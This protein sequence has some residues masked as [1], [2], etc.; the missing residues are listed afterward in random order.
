M[1]FG[2][3]K[4][5]KQPNPNGTKIYAY[6]GDNIVEQLNASGTATARYTQGL[7]IDEPLEVY[8]GGKSYYYHADGLGSIV[9]LTKSTGTA[10][11][12]YFGYNTFGGMPAPSETVANPFRFT[13]R[14]WDSET[15]LYYYRARYYDPS[16][17]R[18]LSED[19]I[20]DAGGG[21]AY[22]YVDNHPTLLVDPLGLQGILGTIPLPKMMGNDLEVFN[23]ALK[24]AKETAC[25]VKG[26]DGALQDYGIKSLAA[27]L[28]RMAPNINVFDGRKS[29]Y[30]YPPN[31]RWA[32]T[33]PKEPLAQ[34]RSQTSAT[35]FSAI[36]SGTRVLLPLLIRSEL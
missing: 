24:Y 23:I 15:S 2:R 6:D 36:I 35:H 11:N 3:N 19:P 28:D 34:W 31:N 33:W 14:D 17:G 21:S 4:F 12:T 32:V 5:P 18:F 9:A 22:I 10:A 8:E 1:L 26:C 20:G 30:P 7:G 27:L 13:G 29:T 25:E 16:I